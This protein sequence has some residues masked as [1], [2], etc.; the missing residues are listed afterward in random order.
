MIDAM[1]DTVDPCRRMIDQITSSRSDDAEE[2]R[3]GAVV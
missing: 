1:I 2:D 3:N